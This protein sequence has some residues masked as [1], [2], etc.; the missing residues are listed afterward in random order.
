[1]LKGFF[2]CTKEGIKFLNSTEF[3]LKIPAVSGSAM[4]T[5][6]LFYRLVSYLVPRVIEYKT[7]SVLISF[8]N[9]FDKKSGSSLYI[10][11]GEAGLPTAKEC[12]V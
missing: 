11:I 1:M 3:F 5:E 10:G 2:C 4:L 6:A 12:T 8:N 7:F 9:L